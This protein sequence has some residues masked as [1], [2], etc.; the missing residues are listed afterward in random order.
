MYGAALLVV[1]HDNQH[2]KGI[3]EISVKDINQGNLVS[4]LQLKEKN[5]NQRVNKL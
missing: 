4:L 1:W 3:F 5:F 2:L